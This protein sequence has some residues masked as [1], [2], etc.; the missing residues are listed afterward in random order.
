MPLTQQLIKFKSRAQHVACLLLA[1]L[2][3]LEAD[4]YINNLD[5]LPSLF[6]FTQ[7]YTFWFE[8]F[9]DNYYEETHRSFIAKHYTEYGNR[10]KS[11]WDNRP[12]RAFSK[13]PIYLI[14]KTIDRHRAK[15]TETNEILE[16][17]TYD[18][19]SSLLELNE[20][21]AFI[22]KKNVKNFAGSEDFRVKVT[23]SY[24][25]SGFLNMD[26]SNHSSDDEEPQEKRP[27]NPFDKAIK[28]K[29]LRKIVIKN[30]T[31]DSLLLVARLK[32]P[33]PEPNFMPTNFE[34][35]FEIKG[36]GSYVLSLQKK[37]VDEPFGE[38]SLELAT[39]GQATREGYWPRQ[40]I[41]EV[42]ENEREDEE[43]GS[44][45]SEEGLKNPVWV[46]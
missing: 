16:V 29:L 22:N 39:L 3:Q 5:S 45:D 32:S 34:I 8:D 27:N 46:I 40:I 13:H 7:P 20:E 4:G 44:E 36:G 30:L 25:G 21:N 33:N 43:E 41:S 28:G 11:L 31:Y 37:R 35:S 6:A 24:G 38:Y 42:G 14:G 9:V 23:N 26:R 12:K 10:I 1:L 19:E 18:I 15:K 2:L 17:E